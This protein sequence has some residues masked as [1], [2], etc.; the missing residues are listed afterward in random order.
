MIRLLL[1]LCAGIFITL[2]VGGKDHGQMRFGLMDA[3][4]EAALLAASVTR[5]DTRTLETVETQPVTR[6]A[7]M[8]LILPKP[9]APV[10]EI[11][12]VSAGQLV[13]APVLE[14]EPAA[15]V[16]QGDMKYVVGR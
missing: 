13:T 8:A 5:A 11:G 14:P 9:S 16:A 10:A 3:E 12:V 6:A 15:P 2:Q 1:L 4:K 7:D